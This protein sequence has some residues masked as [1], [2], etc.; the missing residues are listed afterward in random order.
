MSDK[1]QITGDWDS[2]SGII[3]RP[4][5]IPPKP[6][7][8]PNKKRREPRDDM[9]ATTGMIPVVTEGTDVHAERDTDKHNGE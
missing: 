7:H 4:T 1:P 3:Q 9:G 5:D 8:L 2:P 6:E